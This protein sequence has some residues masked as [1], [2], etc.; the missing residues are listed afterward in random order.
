VKTPLRC[1][2]FGHQHLPGAQ[3]FSS[4]EQREVDGTWLSVRGWC[5]HCKAQLLLGSLWMQDSTAKRLAGAAPSA[6]K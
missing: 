6:T 1:R 4:V 2:L 3:V 5:K